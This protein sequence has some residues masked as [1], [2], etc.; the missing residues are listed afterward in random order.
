LKLSISGLG[1]LGGEQPDPYPHH[2]E[3]KNA[4]KS[5]EELLE[6]HPASPSRLRQRV[7]LD[8]SIGI[9]C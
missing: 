8:G 7:M 6:V 4:P 9:R 5:S 2:A 1:A 3:L